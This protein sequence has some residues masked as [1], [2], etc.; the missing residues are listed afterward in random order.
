MSE[1]QVFSLLGE[2]VQQKSTFSHFYVQLPHFG[3]DL[4]VDN[5]TLTLEA[6]E[7]DNCISVNFQFNELTKHI[8]DIPYESMKSAVKNGLALQ[9]ITLTADEKAELDV[10]LIEWSKDFPEDEWYGLSERYD[11]NAWI[12]EEV[13]MISLYPA[14]MVDGKLETDSTTW[15]TIFKYDVKKEPVLKKYRV[16]VF[17]ESFFYDV[18]AEDREEADNKAMQLYQDDNNAPEICSSDIQEVEDFDS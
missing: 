5:K 11:M 9:D 12:S 7:V 10:Q 14:K 13:C 15:F 3:I 6:L 1:K 16:Q 4:I 18:E 17:H 2:L 8:V